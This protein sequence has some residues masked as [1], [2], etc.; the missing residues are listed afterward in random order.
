MHHLWFLS[1]FVAKLPNLSS[2]ISIEIMACW[3]AWWIVTTSSEQDGLK[4]P[5]H[6][7]HSTF[8]YKNL[9]NKDIKA[10]ILWKC[11]DIQKENFH[12]EIQFKTVFVGGRVEYLR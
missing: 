2:N 9:V 1:T 5:I 8:F 4:P 11:F 7:S 3:T 12:L 6:G 10:E